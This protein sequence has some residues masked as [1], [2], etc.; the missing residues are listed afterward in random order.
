M[1]YVDHWEDLPP[2][3]QEFLAEVREL[4]QRYNLQYG[5]WGAG[6]H[7]VYQAKAPADQKPADHLELHPATPRKQC[8][9]LLGL[10][11]QAKAEVERQL[12]RAPR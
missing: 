3:V 5:I 12:A 6:D 9:A 7:A 11:E 4:E 10:L 1:S 8:K 2:N